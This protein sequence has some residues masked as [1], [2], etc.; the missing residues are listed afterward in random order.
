MVYLQAFWAFLTRSFT[1]PGHIRKGPTIW[2]SEGNLSQRG[3]RPQ[4]LL[5]AII[6]TQRMGSWVCSAMG[7]AFLELEKCVFEARNPPISLILKNYT[8]WMGS[9]PIIISADCKVYLIVEGWG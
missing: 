8:R 1:F 9:L 2:H 5:R 6:R 7:R 3:E 4:R